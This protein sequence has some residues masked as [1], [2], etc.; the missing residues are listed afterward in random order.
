M[1]RH[2]IIPGRHHRVRARQDGLEAILIAEA[3]SPEELKNTKPRVPVIPIG[4]AGVIIVRGFGL[5]PLADLPL[6][7]QIWGRFLLPEGARVVDV[8]GE[9]FDIAV[10]RYQVPAVAL[11]G[12]APMGFGPIVIPVISVKLLFAIASAL[13]TLGWLIKQISVFFFG[14]KDKPGLVTAGSG[15]LVLLI[16]GIV[17][18]VAFSGRVGRRKT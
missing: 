3:R 17:V 18:L 8:R 15:M 4:A 7:E 10:I 11:Q 12:A 2:S 16:G 14:T 13:L 9:G 5:G 1:V 6:A